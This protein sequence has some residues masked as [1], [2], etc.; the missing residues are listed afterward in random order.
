MAPERARHRCL[1]QPEVDEQHQVANRP[2]LG[3]SR[4][5]EVA[6]SSVEL[7]EPKHDQDQIHRIHPQLVEGLGV[8][9]GRVINPELGSD[10][11]VN[12][13]LTIHWVAFP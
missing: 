9:D 2:C 10:R 7:L 6:L 1:L 4:K 13:S 3:K 5:R 8:L 12:E 11:V